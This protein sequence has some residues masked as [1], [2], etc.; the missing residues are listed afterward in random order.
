MLL[1]AKFTRSFSLG[2]QFQPLKLASANACATVSCPQSDNAIV[3]H[4]L[5]RLLLQSTHVP[6]KKP[7]RMSRTSETRL[8]NVVRLWRARMGITQE[9]LAW[10]ASMHRSYVAD[11]ER[12]GRNITV[13][14]LIALAKALQIPVDR[15][16][17][18]APCSDELGEILM[19]ED[20][21][22][23]AELAMRSFRRAGVANQVRVARDGE[24]AVKILFGGR[25]D[26]SSMDALPQLILLD[27]KLPTLSGIEVLRRIK[28]D[29]RTR[30][31]PVVVLTSSRHDSAILECSRL[32]AENYILKPLSFEKLSQLTPTM[33]LQWALLRPTEA[34]IKVRK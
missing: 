25:D 26:Q 33:N 34:P 29:S 18:N 2:A 7:A 16:L 21:A 28:D 32:G 15:L 12:G 4:S 3:T 24:E 1:G 23:D 11:I 27:L 17:S 30:E 31:I 5:L 8:G 19:V 20:N 22:A 13:R 6:K 14:S 10:R 9:E